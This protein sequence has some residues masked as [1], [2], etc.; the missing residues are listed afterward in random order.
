MQYKLKITGPG[1]Q[2]TTGKLPEGK[3]ESTKAFIVAGLGNNGP[4]ADFSFAGNH[5]DGEIFVPWTI[6]STSIIEFIPIYD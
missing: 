4:T 5:S 3:A 2:I 1:Y 6:I